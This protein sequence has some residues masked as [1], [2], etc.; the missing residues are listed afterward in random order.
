MR[1]LLK[2]AHK[3]R[4]RLASGAVATYYYAWRGGPR[5][6]TE[7]ATFE[8]VHRYTEA[9]AAR[10]RPAHGTTMA[11]IAQFKVAAP[12]GFA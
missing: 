2:G 3:V 12:S 1:A 9:Q 11:L 6:N 5:I 4:Y 10:K 8:F 7:P